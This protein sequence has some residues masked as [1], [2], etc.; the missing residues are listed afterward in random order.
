MF[1]CRWPLSQYL[2]NH[3]AHLKRASYFLFLLSKSVM[4]CI[5]NNFRI[6]LCFRKKKKKKW[7]MDGSS[8]L[9]FMRDKNFYKQQ[10]L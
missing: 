3:Y 8:I 2:K 6:Y 1:T 10:F 9:Y 4:C 5:T 7:Y